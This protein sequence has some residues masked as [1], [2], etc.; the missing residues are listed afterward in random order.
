[1]YTRAKL[2]H[3]VICLQNTHCLILYNSKKWGYVG[4]CRLTNKRRKIGR[5]VIKECYLV[6]S[7]SICNG[8]ETNVTEFFI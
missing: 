3:T 4:T 6:M 2:K 7:Q 1:M 8:V 5:D